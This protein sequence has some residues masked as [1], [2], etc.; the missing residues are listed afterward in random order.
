LLG[1]PSYLRPGT[2]R[3]SSLSSSSGCDAD[4]P[5]VRD[6]VSG[7]PDCRRRGGRQLDGAESCLA[8]STHRGGVISDAGYGDRPEAGLAAHVDAG[9]LG[10]GAEPRRNSRATGFQLRRCATGHGCGP[11]GFRFSPAATDGRDVSSP[12]TRRRSRRADLGAPLVPPRAAGRPRRDSE[13]GQIRPGRRGRRR[14][15]TWSRARAGRADLQPGAGA[16]G[17]VRPNP[18]PFAGWTAVCH[19]IV[20]CPQCALQ[21]PCRGRRRHRVPRRPGQRPPRPQP[22]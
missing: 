9:D 18:A 20:E 8:G 19:S 7:W 14:T 21:R 3:S 16:T 5:A 2:S 22:G 10:V 6:R 15:R 17:P 1:G 12:A 13:R 4:T 11:P